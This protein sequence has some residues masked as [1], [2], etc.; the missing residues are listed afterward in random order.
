MSGSTIHVGTCSWAE[1]SLLTSGEFYPRGV[2]SAEERLKYYASRF[3]TVE[4]DATYYAIPAMRTTELWAARTPP[5]FL[6]HIKAYGALTGHGIDPRTLPIPLRALLPAA[7]RERA[8][9]HLQEPQ[10][11]QAIAAAFVEALAPLKA[12]GKLGLIVF[13]FPPWF[14]YQRPDLAFIL[15]CQELTGGLPIAV[16]FR[17]GSWLAQPHR[18][19]VL[20]FLRDHGITHV[21]ADEPQYGTLATVPF[22]PETTTETAYFRLHGRN[23]EAWLKK[24]ADTSARY[25]YLYSARELQDFAETAQRVARQTRRVFVMFNNCRAGHAVR[26]ALELLTLVGS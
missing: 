4:V 19:L 20:G 18:T 13:Q 8:S 16:E 15:R 22:L 24:G 7:D 14:Q 1:R 21:I 26:N 12:A 6:F 3:D 23:R 5:G 10:L 9:L 17:H 11:L 2:S 25:D